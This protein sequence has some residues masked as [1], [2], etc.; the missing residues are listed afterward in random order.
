MDRVISDILSDAE[1]DFVAGGENNN[2]FV[3]VKASATV[4]GGDDGG[5]LPTLPCDS[6]DI[7][8]RILSLF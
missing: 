3:G 4:G 7:I 8:C 6:V 2:S 5:K 1:L